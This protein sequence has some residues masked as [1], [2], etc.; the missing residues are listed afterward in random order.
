MGTAADATFANQLGHFYES[1]GDQIANYINQH[2]DTL[3]QSDLGS[4]SDSQ[5]AISNYANQFFTLSDNIAFADSD[6]YFTQITAATGEITQAL[7]TIAET[8]K[9]INIVAGVITLAE[10]VVTANGGGIVSSLSGL[11]GAIRTH[12]GD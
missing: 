8:N 2:V 10:A 4:L 11:I 9:I 6:G 12:V 5:T 7:N 3:S 1:V